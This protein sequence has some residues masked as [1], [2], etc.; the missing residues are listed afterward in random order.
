MSLDSQWKKIKENWLIISLIFVVLLF[1]T[2][3][4]TI[5]Y[6][7]MNSYSSF[8]SMAYD[9]AISEESM[10]KMMIFPGGSDFAPGV[11]ERIITKNSNLET[12]VE[13]GEFHLSEEIFKKIISD[14][15]ALI[16][17]ENVNK[18]GSERKTYYKGYYTIKAES[19]KYELLTNALKGI[20]EVQDFSENTQDITGQYLD[21][22]TRLEIEEQRL[23]RYQEIYDNSQSIEEKIMITDKLFNQENVV[24][25]LK[26]AIENNDLRVEY[27]TI[28][29]TLTEKRS[30]YADVELIE[31]HKLIQK[32]TDSFNALLSLMF[33][34]IPWVIVFFLGFKAYKKITK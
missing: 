8:G 31:F 23:S 21:L 24:E 3:T 11:E 15:K 10:G 32:I 17:S 22:Q 19:D 28:Y 4:S 18:I 12:E 16:L 30:D 29:F 25:Y 2:L 20:G 6:A 34:I 33:S 13:K 5:P 1:N 7:V 27:S 26:K 9:Q 14:S